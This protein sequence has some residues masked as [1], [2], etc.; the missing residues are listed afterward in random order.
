M[1]LLL[2]EGER[3]IPSQGDLIP[4]DRNPGLNYIVPLP[5]SWTQQTDY[6]LTS[7]S[8]ATGVALYARGRHHQRPA[9]GDVTVRIAKAA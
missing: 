4:K 2:G 8:P 1:T 6:H 9:P 5:P 3:A 7:G